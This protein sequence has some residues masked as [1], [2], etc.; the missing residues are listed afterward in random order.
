MSTTTDPTPETIDPAPL[1]ETSPWTPPAD[2]DVDGLMA[3]A[4]SFRVRIDPATREIYVRGRVSEFDKRATF[5]G[6][7]VAPEGAREKFRTE[8]S[9]KYDADR[10]ADAHALRRAL[11]ETERRLAQAATEARRLRDEPET[12]PTSASRSERLLATLVA[13]HGADHAE[14]RLATMN[15][16]QVRRAYAATAD[17]ADRS[18]ILAVERGLITGTLPADDPDEVLRLTRVVSDRQAARV[19]AAITERLAAIQQV[20]NDHAFLALL[21]TIAATEKRR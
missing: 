3:A 12:L 4:S 8:V 10:A 1:A 7:N 16:G 15:A 20:T 17:H 2:L 6:F 19:P 14:R 21:Q 11:T 9:A 5:D 13:L 18:F